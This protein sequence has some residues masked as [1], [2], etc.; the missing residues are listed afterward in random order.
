MFRGNIVA[1]GDVEKVLMEPKHP[2]VRLLR[3][4]IPEP[5][6]K[7]RWKTKVQLSEH[8][9]VEYLRTGCKFAGRCPEVMEICR[10][11][12]PQDMD[13]DGELVKCHLFQTTS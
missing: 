9:T 8:E 4:C 7:T 1:M 11:E 2:Y 3:E 6:P 10:R 12:V 13:V 5:N